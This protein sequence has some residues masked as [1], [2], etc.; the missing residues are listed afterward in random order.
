MKDAY[1]VPCSPPYPTDVSDDEWLLVA[2]VTVSL[3]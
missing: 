2:P 3:A 1:H